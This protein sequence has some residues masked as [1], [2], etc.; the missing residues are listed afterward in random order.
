MISLARL[1]RDLQVSPDQED[2]L[3]DAR[4]SAVALWE[5]ATDRLWALRTGF[6]EEIRPKITAE[7][8]LRLRLS[9]VSSLSLVEERAAGESDWE[10]LD[11][12]D[13]VLQAPDRLR[14]LD[15]FWAPEVRVTY[16]GGYAEDTAP[17]D[18]LLALVA[19]MRFQSV[20]LGQDRIA[21]RGQTVQ[22]GGATF[23]E[24]GFLVPFFSKLADRHRRKGA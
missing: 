9:P 11:A 5:Q 18:V 10:T 16:S 2:A 21:V 17:A 12:S 4:A 1:R 20:R 14:R 3:A 7:D 15:G 19:Q 13:Y 8:T 22:G 6:V 24:D 23:L